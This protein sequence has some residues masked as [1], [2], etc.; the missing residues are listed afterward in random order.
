[1]EQPSVRTLSARTM[2]TQPRRE[3]ARGKEAQLPGRLRGLST[4]TPTFM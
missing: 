4:A 3:G 1:M 2:D